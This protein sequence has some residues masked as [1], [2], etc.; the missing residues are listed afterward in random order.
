MTWGSRRGDAATT[1]WLL[2]CHTP[3]VVTNEEN[4]YQQLQK[5]PQTENLVSFL[6]LVLVTHKQFRLRC[7]NVTHAKQTVTN[8]SGW[9]TWGSTGNFSFFLLVFN[10]KHFFFSVEGVGGAGSLRTCWL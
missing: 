2:V 10:R 3:S 9:L 7:V 1:P 4:G 8:E 6:H 5:F